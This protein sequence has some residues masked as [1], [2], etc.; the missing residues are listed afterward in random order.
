MADA[1]MPVEN[2]EF[3]P[4]PAD[5]V[6]TTDTPDK[7][8]LIAEPVTPG[9]SMTYLR[10]RPLWGYAAWY[11]IGLV[12][13]YATLGG[14][15]SILLPNQVQA[16]E[17]AR[18]FTGANAHVDL[19]ALENLKNAVANGQVATSAQQVLLRLFGQFDA[20]RAQALALVTSLGTLATTLTQPIVGTLSDRTRSRFGRRAPWLLFGGIVGALCFTCMRYAPTVAI[21]AL[22]MTI[23]QAV[24][25]IAL[26]PLMTTVADR[27]PESRLGT[28][29][30]VSGLALFLGAIAG[31][32]LAS[33]IFASLGLSTYFLF[34]ILPLL[35]IIGF[36]LMARDRSSKALAVAPA[37]VKGFLG[38][39]L[40]PL[41]DRDFRWVWL[42]RV[43]LIFG[44]GTSGALSFYMLQSYIHPALS[45]ADATRL[46]PLF[47]L[48]GLPATLL[49]VVI[50]GRL[51]DKIGR[52][53]PFVIVASLLM[54]ASC[55]VPLVWPTLPAL[56]IQSVSGSF[57]FGIYV[58]VD[59]AL[60]I[61]VLPD[62]K[63]A[64]RDLGIANAG[65][66]IGQ[67]LAPLLAAAVVTLTGGYRMVWV[68]ALLLVLIA[69]V[70]IVPVKRAR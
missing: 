5:T 45:A 24:L 4:A 6:E 38:G 69:A 3:L 21:L 44:S 48:A 35:G 68:A 25:N 52:R 61:D 56:F 23:A 60:F 34:A 49:A 70:S 10:G 63:A 50:A 31:S 28:I 27:V 15:S 53:K 19:T 55:L 57:A 29:S 8:A 11:T 36:V 16:L 41:L 37:N 1:D 47:S 51:S 42:A 54:A 17:F 30:S 9:T 26:G 58:P 46:V 22:L 18:Y 62:K 67:V 65:T 43:V 13:I 33:V 66:T 7:T 64:G 14:V 2:T 59:T 32:G 39:F 40:V 20:D 12:T